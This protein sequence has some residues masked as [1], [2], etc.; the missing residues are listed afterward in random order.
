LSLF[1]VIVFGGAALVTR[2]QLFVMLKPTLIY[3]AI[4]AV[5]LRPGWMTRY[6]PAI[7]GTTA[8]DVAVLF[9]YLWAAL[10]F[11]TAAA[12]LLLA[13]QASQTAWAWFIGGFPLVSKLAL[14]LLQYVTTR[15]VIRR[16]RA[17][18]SALV[19]AV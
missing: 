6:V 14:V 15:A 3:A 18:P 11:A 12:N 16:R 19:P 2:D 4:G 17:P 9:G 7:V 5:M 1:L 8:A 10:M 13:L